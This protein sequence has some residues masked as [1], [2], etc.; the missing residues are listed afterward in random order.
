[1]YVEDADKFGDRR[2]DCRIDSL[3]HDARRHQLSRHR[4]AAERRK[5]PG[6]EK[7]PLAFSMYEKHALKCSPICLAPIG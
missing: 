5:Q 3:M 1:M 6:Q 7:L 4:R 2:R